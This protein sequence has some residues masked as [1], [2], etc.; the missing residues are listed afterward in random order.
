M[1]AGDEDEN[2]VDM[3]VGHE[4]ETAVDGATNTELAPQPGELDLPD[5]P[6]LDDDE[7]LREYLTALNKL[8]ITNDEAAEEVVKD[9]ASP[10][11]K[12]RKLTEGGAAV[13]TG[14]ETTAIAKG[15]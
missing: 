7:S 5:V 2:I 3:T 6:L 9:V 4:H 11:Q 12:K 8:E 15:R 10:Q 14:S 1:A 13:V